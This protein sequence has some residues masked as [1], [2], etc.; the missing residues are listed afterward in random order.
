MLEG[1]P[2]VAGIGTI[3]I[4]AQANMNSNQ[5]L[6]FLALCCLAI[7]NP[8]P[9]QTNPLRAG[10]AK[11]DITPAE[12]C[13]LS[14]YASRTALSTGVHDPLSARA[15]AFEQSG[16]RLVMVSCDVIG[17]YAGTAAQMRTA[18]CEAAKLDP[19]ELFLA[20][21]HTHSAPTLTLDPTKPSP[22]N[23]AY[24]Q[25][26]QTKLLKLVQDALAGLCP[27]SIG[28]GRGSSPVGINRRQVVIGKDGHR[29][30]RLGR[31]PDGSTDHEV[32][33]LQ[34]RES[35][36]DRLAALLFDYAT[37]GTSLGAKN[38]T[39]S[40]DVPGLAEQFVEN[41]LGDGVLAP[42]FVGASGDIDPWFRVLPEFK[43]GNGWIPEPVL[44]GTMLGEEVVTTGSAIRQ[45]LATSP[46]QTLLK[47]VELPLKADVQLTDYTK[48]TMTI[49]AARI[50]DVA[51]IGLSGEVFHEIGQAI[52]KASPFPHTL[53]ITHCN[54]GSGYLVVKEAYPEGGYEVKTTPFAPEAAGMVLEETKVLLTQLRTM[55]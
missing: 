17:F 19:S 16:K 41:Y 30:I 42:V 50:G 38:L 3:P 55:K 8:A 6:C 51:F 7:S 46:I 52:K 5:S 20:G 9:G 53:V 35:G 12:P 27:V 33:V 24:T 49:T 47:T 48:N 23:F 39:V 4:L 15:I 31:N 34:I 32:Q 43:T 45:D 11:V 26:L 14:G 22:S 13:V 10:F 29:E 1:L 2:S 37:H 25:S 21:I 18:I 40:G 28:A 54:G 44:L 36:N